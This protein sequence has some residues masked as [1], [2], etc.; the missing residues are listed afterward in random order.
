MKKSAITLAVFAAALF[1]VSCQKENGPASDSGAAELTPM[2]FNAVSEGIGVVSKVEMAYKYDLLWQ[3]NDEILVKDA[4]NSANFKLNGGAGTTKGT[5]FCES[6]PFKTGDAVEAFYPESIVSGSDLVWAAT[7]TADK[8]VPMYSKKTLSATKNQTFSFASLGSVLQLIFSTTSKDVI[9]KSIEVKA[10]E[11]M[12]GKFTINEKGEAVISQPDG[13][14]KPG[15]T[16]DLG[17]EGV[18]VGV[19]AKKF[20]IAIPAGEY[21]GLSIVFTATDGKK[22]TIN[23]KKDKAIE[24]VFN[25]VNTLAVS[26]KFIPAGALPGEFSVSAD[27]KVHF[28]Q[29]N[30]VATINATGAPTAWKFA[31]NQYDYLGEGGANKTIGKKAGDVDLFGWSTNATSNNWGIHTKTSS[32]TGFTT[33]SFNDWGATIGDKSTWC[34]LS[35][36]EW[37][38]LFDTSTR[39]VN[40]KAC[41]SNAMSG[42]TIGGSTYKGVF[43]YPD[44]YNGEIVSSSMTW[45]D[46]N[47]AGIVFLPAAGFR[48][49]STVTFVGINGGYW[50]SSGYSDNKA[51][52]VSFSSADVTPDNR[53]NRYP[54]WSV[55]LITVCQ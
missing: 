26:G 27:K 45:N 42:V 29:G 37:K 52:R 21:H 17:D 53:D 10:D 4:S 36:G 48:S 11:A 30:L 38:Y 28:S 3:T 19:T 20:N 33:G 14:D 51:C 5:F 25:T 55:R 50:S 43:L 39:M 40:G 1:A 6:S 16:L 24:I 13:A 2:T 41:Y 9:L 34:T 49:G 46:I 23:A 31:T 7:L 22:C 12:S 44:N 35:S 8:T 47:A 32:T 54:G 18:K 15:I